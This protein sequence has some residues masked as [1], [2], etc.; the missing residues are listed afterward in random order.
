MPL[1]VFFPPTTLA[2]APLGI[3][4]K[5]HKHTNFYQIKKVAENYFNNLFFIL[6]THK[7]SPRLANTEVVGGKKPATA[8]NYFLMYL[9]YKST[10]QP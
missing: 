7:S 10:A 2:E 1:L 4:D 3:A 6:G 9:D 8:G 5:H